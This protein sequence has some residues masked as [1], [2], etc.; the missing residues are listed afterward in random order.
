VIWLYRKSKFLK[1]HRRGHRNMYQAHY[2]GLV[3][4]LG[5][6]VYLTGQRSGWTN[7]GVDTSIYVVLMLFLAWNKL[8]GL[9]IHS[10]LRNVSLGVGGDDHAYS[11]RDEFVDSFN[12]IKVSKL[13]V[14]YGFVI[15]SPYLDPVGL[16]EIHF[17][18]Q[19]L[20]LVNL[21]GQQIWMTSSNVAKIVSAFNFATSLDETKTASRF[22]AL[23][24]M[25]YPNQVEY[26]IMRERVLK[27]MMGTKVR[28]EEF[29]HIARLVSD[30]LYPLRI[31]LR[32]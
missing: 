1:E 9:G 27:W 14:K 29:L 7:T 21:N 5:W 19:Q 32:I 2:C 12:V 15:E 6:L 23:L 26:K 4:V 20:V 28:T 17:F 11:V 3:Y 30:D 24:W 18:S 13:L 31:Y 10:F 16:T 25:L 8:T 22:L